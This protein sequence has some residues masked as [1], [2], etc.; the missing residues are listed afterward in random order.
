MAFSVS[1]AI[2]IEKFLSPQLLK[3]LFSAAVMCINCFLPCVNTTLG[4]FTKGPSKFMVFSLPTL[5]LA[6][7]TSFVTSKSKVKLELL[8]NNV[9][10]C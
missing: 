9:T 4:S 1:I 7:L 2:S 8:F 6:A 5:S 10:T 3:L